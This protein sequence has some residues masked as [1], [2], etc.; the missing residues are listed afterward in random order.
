[1]RLDAGQASPRHSALTSCLRESWLAPGPDYQAHA[2]LERG[3][4]DKNNKRTAVR[5]LNL[6]ATIA[7]AA[8][9]SGCDELKDGFIRQQLTDRT[10]YSLLED[11][12]SIRVILCGTG[13]PQKGGSR[14]Q[15]CTLVSA[16]GRLFL[17]DAGENAMRNLENSQVPLAALQDIFITHWHSDHF[18]GLGALI[19]H[20]W[21]WG[22]H[23]PVRVHGPGAVERV[24][25]GL[26]QVYAD[27][28]HHRN[29]HFVA[30]PEV[31][32]GQ[33][34]PFAIPEAR[35]S[36]RIYD[37]GGVS[38]DAYRVA[39]EPV[40]PAVGYLLSYAGRKVFI[41]GDTKVSPRYA[42]ALDDADLVI[43]EAINSRLVADAARVASAMGRTEDATLMNHVLEY[44]ADTLQLA[45]LAQ[46]HRVKHL[47]LTH[48]IPEP[49]NPISRHL[50]GAGMGERYDGEITLAE[51]GMVIALP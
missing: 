39:H 36:L 26:A 27:D 9:L 35:E 50:F 37:E 25:Q 42:K 32:F 46:A 15:A 40:E 21:I 22:R 16:G 13:S 24:M 43:H 23:Q 12:G 28:A 47:V 19:N 38:I 4:H 30:T 7:L 11:N 14:G 29:Q 51:D 44:H 6:L 17:F 10:D 41:S 2:P 3:P 18:N 20:S 8:L 33:A 31:A 1:M 45:E 49:N 5:T 48:T 34:R